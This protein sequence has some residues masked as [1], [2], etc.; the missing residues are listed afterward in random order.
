M[1]S[2]PLIPAN[3]NLR[4]ME[5]PFPIDLNRQNSPGMYPTLPSQDS[6]LREYL[7]VLIKRKWVV[8][9]SLAIIFAAV[10]IA[11]LRSTPIYDAAGSIAMHAVNI[12]KR[13][14]SCPLGHEIYFARP[15]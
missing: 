5:G 11:T 3:Q 4:G 10:A 9:S 14:I 12:H 8:V 1:D 2:G 13:F 7:R 15:V 6:V